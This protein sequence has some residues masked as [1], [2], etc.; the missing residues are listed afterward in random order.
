MELLQLLCKSFALT[1]QRQLLDHLPGGQFHDV[2]DPQMITE[3]K[4]VPKTNVTPE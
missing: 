1:I 2:S 3:A 4:S